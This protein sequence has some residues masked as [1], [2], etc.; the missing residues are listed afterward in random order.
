MFDTRSFYPMYLPGS[1]GTNQG[2]LVPSTTVTAT[3]S[4]ATASTKFGNEN[5]G[6]EQVRIANKTTAWAHINCGV[7]GNVVAATVAASPCIAP[8]AVE[9]WSIKA[10]VTG[11]SVILD[12]A[13]GTATAV[14]FTR[15]EGI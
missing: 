4:S 3:N 14:I 11:F 5:S 15:G 10:E 6:F 12:A 2:S 1:A 9:V 13:P 7:F 8:G